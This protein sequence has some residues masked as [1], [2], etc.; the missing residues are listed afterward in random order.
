VGCIELGGERG[1][2]KNPPR[3]HRSHKFPELKPSQAKPSTCCYGEFPQ[4][5]GVVIAKTGKEED[6]GVTK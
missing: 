2:I 5:C 3:D 4:I 1:A 6:R